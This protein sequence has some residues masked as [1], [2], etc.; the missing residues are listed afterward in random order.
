MTL[1]TYGLRDSC[2][3]ILSL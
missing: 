2:L 1:V 3:S